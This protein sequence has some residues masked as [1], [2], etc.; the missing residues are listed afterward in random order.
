MCL[1]NILPVD[2]SK[3]NK[4]IIA[5]RTFRKGKDGTLLPVRPGTKWEYYPGIVYQSRKPGFHGFYTR[6]AARSFA[7]EGNAWLRPDDPD[8]E[9]VYMVKLTGLYTTGAQEI[10][11][12]LYPA[13][14]ARFMTV[15]ERVR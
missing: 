14:T 2:K 1:V 4:I 13:F 6:K 7:K 3:Q 10:A 15:L 9:R 8:Y 5:Y 12:E 11:G